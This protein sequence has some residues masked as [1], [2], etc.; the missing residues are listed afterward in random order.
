MK[1]KS[2]LYT[3]VDERWDI[4]RGDRETQNHA[5]L[6]AF[7]DP[8]FKNDAVWVQRECQMAEEGFI[9]LC[10]RF[11]LSG[12]AAQSVVISPPR[13]QA[14][15]GLVLRPRVPDAYDDDLADDVRLAWRQW[16]KEEIN[17]SEGLSCDVLDWWKSNSARFPLIAK[18]AKIVL[19]TP[20][21]EAICERLFK[22]AKHIGTTDRMAR[23]LD[24]TFEMLVMA[25]YNIS[26]HGGVETI[27]VNRFYM[28]I[29][30][31]LN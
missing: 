21:S 26:R 12:Y 22:R 11:K 29:L 4:A 9:Q 2:L 31:C 25:Q 7:L 23:L 16:M 15:S 30:S 5:L 3:L 1:A 17:V 20:A 19:A 14:S 28:A 13:A 6:A 18:A 10:S 24:D 8:R 27:E